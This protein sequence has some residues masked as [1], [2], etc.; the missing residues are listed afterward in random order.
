MILQTG[1]RTD[2][3]AFYSKW[4]LRR[5]EAGFVRVRNPYHPFK[6]TQYST[7]PEHVDFIGFTSKNPAPLLKHWQDFKHY[8][9]LWHVTLTAYGSDLEPAVPSR[10]H[11]IESIQALSQNLGPK[12]VVWRYD[13]I[14][15]NDTYTVKEHIASF[16]AIGKALKGYVD[17]VITSFIDLYPSVVMLHPELTRPP[18]DLQESILKELLS[19]TQDLGIRLKTCGEGKRFSHLGLD[20]SDCYSKEE[21]ARIFNK[22]FQLPH[23]APARSTCACYLH[24]DIGQYNTCQHFCSYCYANTERETVRYNRGL[25]DS[26]SPFLIGHERPEDIITLASTDLYAK[27]YEPQ[28][29]SL[30]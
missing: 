21:F 19:I 18:F 26:Q 25:H 8:E 15:I 16:T 10:E 12:K 28:Q 5:L 2:I 11:V 29:D 1:Q 27:P 24:G 6:V 22:D 7:Q 13:P 23:K 14:I 17:T 3:P 20:T 30:F 9:Q 4:F